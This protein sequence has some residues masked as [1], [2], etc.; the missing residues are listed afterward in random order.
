MSS[1]LESLFSEMVDHKKSIFI[2]SHDSFDTSYSGSLEAWKKVESYFDPNISY[3]V[4]DDSVMS[5]VGKIQGAKKALVKTENWSVED[6]KKRLEI[7]WDSVHSYREIIS[8]VEAHFQGTTQKFQMQW[9]VEATLNLIQT[10]LE[11]VDRIEETSSKGLIGAVTPKANS[12]FE[13]GQRII[14][15]LFHRDCLVIKPA[16]EGTISAFMW[17]EILKRCDLPEGLIAFV[18]G[19]GPVVGRFLMD[20]PGVRHVSFSGSYETLKN[21]PLS[22]EKKYQF[23]FNGKNSMCV[24]GD[25]DYRAQMKDIVRVFIEH[26]GKNVFSPARIFVLDSIEKEFKL[27]LAQCLETIPMLGSIHDYFGFLPLRHS[28]TKKLNALKARFESEEAKIIYGNDR[29]LFYSDLANC[30][31]LHQENLELPMYNLTSVKY[32]HEMAKWV[33]NNSFGHS[34]IIFGPEEKSKKLVQRSEVGQVFFNP[35]PLKPMSVRPVKGS[36][37]G[38][39]D[40]ELPNFFYSYLKK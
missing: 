27:E 9:T 12:F 28:E 20:H 16:T 6:V 24:L 33:N 19:S 38:D 29:L 26:N 7:I 37:F 13:I 18:Y 10:S 35:A 1:L 11:Y 8:S 15:G 22:I 32:A 34:L 23:F 30:S 5:V 21:Y 39:V 25:F 17:S 14:Y 40:L 36:G 3:Y 31:E 2:R 4:Q